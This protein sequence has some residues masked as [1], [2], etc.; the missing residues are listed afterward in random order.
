M[1][2]EDKCWTWAKIDGK[3][4]SKTTKFGVHGVFNKYGEQVD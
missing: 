2:R 1:C 4:I 3:F